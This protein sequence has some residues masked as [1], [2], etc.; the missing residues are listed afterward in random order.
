MVSTDWQLHGKGHTLSRL[1][2]DLPRTD[3]QDLTTLTCLT[4][5]ISTS[6]GVFTLNSQLQICIFFCN[7][8]YIYICLNSVDDTYLHH[9]SCNYNTFLR[10]QYTDHQS[11]Q[12]LGAALSSTLLIAC[13]RSV[14]Y[15]LSGR[16]TP[17]LLRV[18]RLWQPYTRITDLSKAVQTYKMTSTTLEQLKTEHFAVL[19]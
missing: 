19:T 10:Q 14:L 1:L 18:Y 2:H 12:V 13:T 9:W 6:L 7:L 11:L 5:F 3:L 16:Q 8:N 4:L 15:V 17:L